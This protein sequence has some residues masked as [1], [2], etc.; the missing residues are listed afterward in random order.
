[1]ADEKYPLGK[2]LWLATCDVRKLAEDRAELEWRHWEEG[3]GYFMTKGEWQQ[4]AEKFKNAAGTALSE[5]E[6][7]Q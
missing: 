2:L 6:S 4:A 5:K 7:P 3:E 1:M